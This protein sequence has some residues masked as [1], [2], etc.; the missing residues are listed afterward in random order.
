MI[1]QLL[2]GSSFGFRLTLLVGAGENRQ[3][4]ICLFLRG[5]QIWLKGNRSLVLVGS[6]D[7]LNQVDQDISVTHMIRIVVLGRIW[8]CL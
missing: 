2:L 3:E 4:L 7:V 1:R 6:R 8:V 5:T